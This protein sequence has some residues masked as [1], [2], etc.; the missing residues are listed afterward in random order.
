MLLE[1]NDCHWSHWI[2]L[3]SF[4]DPANWHKTSVNFNKS[5]VLFPRHRCFSLRIV[6][7]ECSTRT[8]VMCSTQV[9]LD[10]TFYT[11]CIVLLLCVHHLIKV[12]QVPHFRLE[13]LTSV[14]SWTVSTWLFLHMLDHKISILVRALSIHYDY[15]KVDFFFICL[16]IR[17]QY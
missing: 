8:I 14:K 9:R 4:P 3:A 7:I 1:G 11:Y 13:G 15:S 2:L 16:I 6:L 17:Y 5:W 12:N 10:I